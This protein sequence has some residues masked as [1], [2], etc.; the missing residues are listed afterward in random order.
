MMTNTVERMFRVD[1]PMPKPGLRR[2]ARRGTQRAGVKL[3]DLARDG[4][5]A[6]GATGRR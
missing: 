6:S 3:K 4:S 1:N 2:I 5:A